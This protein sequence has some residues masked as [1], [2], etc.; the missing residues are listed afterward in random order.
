MRRCHCILLFVLVVGGGPF[1]VAGDRVVVDAVLL[2]PMEQAEVPAQEAGVLR[3]LTATEGQIVQVGDLLAQIDDQ[4]ARLEKSRA[5]IELN[6]AR[7]NAQN[8]I[9][10]RVAK[11][12]SEVAAAELQRALDSQKRYPKSVSE[13]EVDRLK[14]A[15]EHA[16]LEVALAEYEF[17]TAQLALQIHENSL[18]RAARQIERRRV[19]AP[20]SGRVVQVFRRPGEWV[21]PGQSVVRILR[22]DRLKAGG[23]LPARDVREDLTGRTVTLRLPGLPATAGFSGKVGYVG[24]EVNPVSGQLD[25][26][27]EIENRG[28]ALRPG[29]KA[30]LTIE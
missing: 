4:D 20:L 21:Q 24:S 14:L 12:A 28:L 6:N 7:R 30:T 11:K 8:D 13:T 1:A 5:E 19:T 26:W 3:Q 27:A 25:F 29:L 23:F 16:A 17:Q 18:T 9:R 2:A 22:I 15:A 10:V